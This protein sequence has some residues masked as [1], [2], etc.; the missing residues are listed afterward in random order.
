M[1]ATVSSE[2]VVPEP[3]EPEF[4]STPAGDLARKASEMGWVVDSI[5]AGSASAFVNDICESTTNRQEVGNEPSESIARQAEYGNSREV[6]QAGMRTMCPKWSKVALAGHGYCGSARDM[7][8]GEW[9][10]LGDG[11]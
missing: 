4:P 10:M 9:A 11:I 7:A 3:M 1:L 8:S 5:Y 2:P 6:L